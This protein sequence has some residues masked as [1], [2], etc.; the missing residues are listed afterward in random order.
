MFRRTGLLPAPPVP[1]WDDHHAGLQHGVGFAQLVHS[2]LLELQLLRVQP[3]PWWLHLS[4]AGIFPA[5]KKVH[6]FSYLYES[7]YLYTYLEY[8]LLQVLPLYPTCILVCVS[9][10]APVLTG[11]F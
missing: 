1:H 9:V 8:C 4:C 7:V 3:P 5:I 11:Q 6:A 10:L 2:L